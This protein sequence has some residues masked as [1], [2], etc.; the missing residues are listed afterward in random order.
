MWEGDAA[1]SENEVARV[2]D[3]LILRLSEILS[4]EPVRFKV[5]AEDF[6]LAA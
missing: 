6:G 4:K 2:W 3:P 1:G 5:K